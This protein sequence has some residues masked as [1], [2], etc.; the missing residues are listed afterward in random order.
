MGLGSPP[1]SEFNNWHTSRTYV[2][3]LFWRRHDIGY[4][5]VDTY[6]HFFTIIFESFQFFSG[7]Y[8]FILFK[9][10]YSKNYFHWSMMLAGK[11]YK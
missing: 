9:N 4:M 8:N 7:S 3:L 10:I 11:F 5:Y 2:R 6:T 1:Y